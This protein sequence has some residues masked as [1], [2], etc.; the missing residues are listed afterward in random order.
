MM[1]KDVE[2]LLEIIEQPE[3]RRILN[4]IK[5]DEIRHAKIVQTLIKLIK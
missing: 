1:K 5:K 4:I 3:S 2:N